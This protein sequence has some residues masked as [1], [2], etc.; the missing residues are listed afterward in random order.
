MQQAF[1]M[2]N[3]THFALHKHKFLEKLHLPSLAFT[4]KLVSKKHPTFSLSCPT[5][6]SSKKVLS[7]VLKMHICIQAWKTINQGRV[8]FLFQSRSIVPARKED[9]PSFSLPT[10]LSTKNSFFPYHLF[11]LH[12]QSWV[13][14]V[15]LITYANLLQHIFTFV[16]IFSLGRSPVSF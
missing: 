4:C 8:R 10:Q 11:F 6:V 7:N 3:S 15:G 13:C 9:M 2:K 14:Q 5:F 1:S 16:L 12:F